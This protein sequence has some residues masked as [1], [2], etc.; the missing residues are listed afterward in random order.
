MA[1]QLYCDFLHFD[2]TARHTF[3]DKPTE[4]AHI[5][6]R[7]HH[8]NDHISYLIELRSALLH[9]SN[10]LTSPTYIV[11]LEVLSYIF[12]Q[13][14]QMEWCPPN[15]RKS[16]IPPQKAMILSAVSRQWRQV[17]LSTSKLW[18]KV[19]CR[20]FLKLY[21]DS[22]L[23][24]HC[25]IYASSL[26]VSLLDHGYWLESRDETFDT[27]TTILS[28]SDVTRKLKTLNLRYI[29]S[30][31][32]WIHLLPSFLRL[33]SLTISSGEHPSVNLSS[34]PLSRVYLSDTTF[35]SLILPPSVLVLYLQGSS[36]RHFY[37]LLGNSPR[38]PALLNPLALN[39]LKELVWSPAGWFMEA[40]SALELSLPAIAYLDLSGSLSPA[41]FIMLCHQFS[42]SLESLTLKA[43]PMASTWSIGDLRRLFKCPAPRLRKLSVTQW[44]HISLLD[45]LSVLTPGEGEEQYK[46]RCLPKLEYLYIGSHGERYGGEFN[47]GNRVLELLKMRRL[48]EDS[49]FHLDFSFGNNSNDGRMI[50]ELELLQ[51][52][53][54]FVANCQ[55]EITIKGRNLLPNYQRRLSPWIYDKIKAVYCDFLQP[56]KTAGHTFTDKPTEL[57]YINE[58]LHHLDDHISKL[59]ELRSALL[60]RSNQLTSLIYI[61][62]HEVLSWIF[63]QANEMKWCLPNAKKPII[64][65]HNAMVLSAVSHQWRQ[66]AFSTSKLW[67]KIQCQIPHNLHSNSSFLIQH[68]ASYASSLDITLLGHVYE[69]DVIDETCDAF[70][71]VLS[72]SDVTRK[73][74]SLQLQ[75]HLS[76]QQIQLIPSFLQLES[77]TINGGDHPSVDLGS[78]QLSR[79]Y[80]FYATFESIT[81]PPSVLILHLRDQSTRY[82][83]T[84]LRDCPRLIKFSSQNSGALMPPI[85]P[86]PL[87]LDSLKS[88]VWSPAQRLVEAASSIELKIPVIE[89]LK[90]N[91]S[92]G[93]KL[94]SLTLLCHQISASLESLTLKCFPSRDNWSIVDLRHLFTFPIPA[95]RKLSL[96]EWSHRSILGAIC[97]LTPDES[98]DGYKD[99]CLPKLEYLSISSVGKAYGLGFDF[100]TRVLDLVKRRRIGEDSPFQLNFSFIDLNAYGAQRQVKWQSDLLQELKENKEDNLSSVTSM[101]S[102]LY[103]NFLQP[104]KTERYAFAD[105]PAELVYVKEQVDKLDHHISELSEFRSALLHR[106]NQLTCPT[107]I[108][109]PEVLPYIFYLTNE[110]D[111]GLRLFP[112]F[113]LRKA[114]ILTAV[115]HQW[116]QVALGTPKLWERVK[117]PVLSSSDVTGKLKSLELK[118]DPPPRWIRLLSSFLR[119]ESL[120]IGGSRYPSVDLSSLPYLSRVHLSRAFFDSLILPPSVLMLHLYGYPIHQSIALLYNCPRLVE[121]SSERFLEEP[122]PPTSNPLVLDRLKTLVWLPTRTFVEVVSATELKIPVIENLELCGSKGLRLAPLTLLCHQFSASITSL[123]LKS[124]YCTTDSSIEDLR[125]LFQFP[126]PTLQKLSLTRWS[127][128]F[129]LR[130]IRALTPREGEDGY[131]DRCLPNLRYLFIG[132]DG[133]GSKPYDFDFRILDLVKRRRIGEDSPFHLDFSCTYDVYNNHASW[134]PELMEEFREFVASRRMEVTVGILDLLSI[135]LGG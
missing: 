38:P 76:P 122:M 71:T 23:F 48:G 29:P 37:T 7:L 67:E 108:L 13:T 66:V 89:K 88:L 86:N 57:A 83:F 42:A 101:A 104:D 65:P 19:E 61:I 40:A 49:P 116:R 133:S 15:G 73:L 114:M 60:H 52:L 106:L 87:V 90:L 134:D 135:P 72:S 46:N 75:C 102:H 81:L 45:A 127:H 34:L 112:I 27:T 8:L 21:R 105:D 126:I 10:Q 103:C 25:A 117:C 68:C 43:L 99:R 41:P 110:R 31:A 56:D 59:H 26:D 92:T 93:L 125:H 11:P 121:F 12:N 91:D 35:D 30:P 94:A 96:I 111:R 113:V 64:P 98:E 115:S 58:Q 1:F 124:F 17:A 6:E 2:K 84:L 95:L 47:F 62:P 63:N 107:Y 74:K 20:G 33:E 131:R 18:E 28:S 5:N 39:N 79:V 51:E 16:I 118:C 77:L 129:T 55:V 9:R 100:D 109:P 14:N 119:L 24:Q 128:E 54:E 78:L 3:T 120:T 53:K 82:S 22:S 132:N 44:S 50:L 69:L 36:T 85:P 130:A 4:L 80:L 97:A 32:K 70:T 123:I